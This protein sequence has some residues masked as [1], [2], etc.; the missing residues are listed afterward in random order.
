MQKLRFLHSSINE[1]AAEDTTVHIEER[2]ILA[3]L[4]C[5]EDSSATEAE[6]IDMLQEVYG[7]FNYPELLARCSI[8]FTDSA[9]NTTNRNDSLIDPLI[10]MRKVMKKLST[11]IKAIQNP[12]SFE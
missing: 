9:I 7:E 1:L 10:E 11:N 2:W 4:I 5:I 8:Y 12:H 3:A 6:K